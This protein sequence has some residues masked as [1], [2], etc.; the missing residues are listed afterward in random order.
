M[1]PKPYE[2][3]HWYQLGFDTT[4]ANRDMQT[5]NSSA[6]LAI[7][8]ECE[9]PKSSEIDSFRSEGDEL[10]KLGFVYS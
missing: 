8:L 6:T 9:S 1:A 3:T 4:D 2:A 7:E 5:L 10:N